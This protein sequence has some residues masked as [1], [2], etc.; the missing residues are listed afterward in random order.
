M[1]GGWGINMA[2]IRTIK[3]EF[4]TSAQVAECSRNARLLFVLMW[5]HCDDNGVHPASAKQLR[6]ECFPGDDDMTAAAVQALVDELKAQGLLVEYENSGAR[7][8][9]VTGWKHQRIDKPQPGKYPLPTDANSESVTGKS[10]EHSATI[11]GTFPPEGKGRERKGSEGKGDEGSEGSRSLSAAADR[12]PEPVGDVFEHWKTVLNHP[13]AKLD[14]KRRKAISAALR[15]GYTADQLKAAIDGCSR[16][17]H[18]MGQNDRH[19]VYDDLGLILRDADHIDRF[20]RNSLRSTAAVAVDA[21]EADRRA[22]VES[23][24]EYRRRMFGN[25]IDGEV[26]A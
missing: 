17:P 8:W 4:C 19:T 6:M 2:R 10:T 7:Y 9:H 23:A 26:V 14:D 20:I 1:R 22:T 11:P 3:P 25:V 16:T 24:L 5:M 18:N 13:T 12:G 21:A 15:I